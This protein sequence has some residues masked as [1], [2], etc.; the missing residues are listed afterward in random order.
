QDR[1]RSQ[2][3][4][5]QQHARLGAGL[6]ATPLQAL[7]QTVGLLSNG[8]ILHVAGLPGFCWLRCPAH[9][10][11]STWLSLLAE[12]SFTSKP[13]LDCCSKMF[14]VNLNFKI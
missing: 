13:Y 11:H 12:Y 3:I 9:A 1:M 10:V 4:N 7:D 2:E 6:E 14:P 5:L 8:L